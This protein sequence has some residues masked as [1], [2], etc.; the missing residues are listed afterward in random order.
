MQFTARIDLKNYV[1]AWKKKAL[2]EK[3]VPVESAETSSEERSM[4]AIA[5]NE[6]KQRRCKVSVFVCL[7]EDAGKELCLRFADDVNH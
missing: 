2:I 3:G 7:S 6:L 4:S 1:H 5:I